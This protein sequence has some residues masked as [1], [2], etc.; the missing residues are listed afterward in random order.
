MPRTRNHIPLNLAASVLFAS[1]LAGACSTRSTATVG[2][3]RRPSSARTPAG[4]HRRLQRLPHAHAFR[5]RT[6]HAGTELL[7]RFQ[8]LVA[9]QLVHMD[10]EERQ[11]LAA[12][13]AYL[14]DEELAAL[15]GRITASI[16]SAPG[17]RLGGADRPIAQ[18]PRARP[19]GGAALAG[20]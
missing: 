3:E 17:G 7:R 15:S 1:T 9:E 6:G 10:L 5:R 18:R 14:P 13:W 12:L 16:P 20:C 11:V 8:V 2:S 19:H 4:Q